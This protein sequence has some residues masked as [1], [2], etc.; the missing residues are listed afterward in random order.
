MH[1][2]LLERWE[3]LEALQ[4]VLAK[5]QQETA[6]LMEVIQK[7]LPGVEETRAVRVAASVSVLHRP[8]VIPFPRAL[9]SS[10][11]LLYSHSPFFPLLHCRW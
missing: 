3:E 6:D 4:P 11:L 5:S 10:C 7:R 1:H 9:C 8:I 2:L